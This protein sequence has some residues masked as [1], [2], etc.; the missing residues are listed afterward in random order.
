VRSN[1][2]RQ[3]DKAKAEKTLRSNHDD[4]KRFTESNREA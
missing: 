3:Q 4:N 1:A 2:G